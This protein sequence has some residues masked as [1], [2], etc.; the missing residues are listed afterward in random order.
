MWDE[1][2]SGALLG[3]KMQQDGCAAPPES[4]LL[5]MTA[6]RLARPASTWAWYTHWRAEAG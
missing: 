5:A 3:E 1:R 6:Q 2:G 4:A